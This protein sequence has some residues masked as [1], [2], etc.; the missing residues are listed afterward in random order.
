[1]AQLHNARRIA[2]FLP[3]PGLILAI[4][5]VGCSQPVRGAWAEEPQDSATCGCGIPAMCG[6]RRSRV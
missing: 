6:P 5:A 1:V 4:A 2:P 3:L